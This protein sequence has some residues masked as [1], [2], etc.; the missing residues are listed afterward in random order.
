MPE[1]KR[2][3]K[4]PKCG[5]EDITEDITLEEWF[6]YDCDWEVP[7]TQEEKDEFMKRK[8]DDNG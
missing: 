4:C 1:E 6:C 5:S 3:K 8:E 2:F 7:W